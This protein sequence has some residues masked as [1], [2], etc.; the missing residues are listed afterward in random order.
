MHRTPILTQPKEQ[1]HPYSITPEGQYR[2][3]SAFPFRTVRESFPQC[4]FTPIHYEAGYAYPLI[5]WM[6]GNESSELEL[7][8]VMPLVSTRN[9]VAVAPRGTTRGSTS[10]RFSWNES[11]EDI[12]ETCLRVRNSIE[13]AKDRFHIHPERV[14]VAGYAD[15]GTMALRVGMEHPDLFAGAI[16]LSGPVPRG[17]QPLRCI[18][19][20][21]KLP[22]MLSVSPTQSEYHDSQVL[23]DLRLLHL[24]GFSLSLRLYPEGDGLTTTMLSDMNSW[25]MS[26]FCE[27]SDSVIW[28]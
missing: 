26:Q 28:H 16:S 17:C 19:Q 8:Q 23:D 5:V 27:T 13:T 25:V 20:A 4:F 14:F 15:G 6:H 12:A 9:Y 21:R 2:S 18:N 7:R 1:F 3:N 22:L 11:R 10:R 24:G